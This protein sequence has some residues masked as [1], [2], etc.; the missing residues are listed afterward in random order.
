MTRA[1][2]A[3]D[4]MEE[5]A[6]SRA[7]AAPWHAAAVD[8]AFA[9]PGRACIVLDA[10][11]RIRRT[12]GDVARYLST[13]GAGPSDLE[14]A[15]AEPV[16]SLLRRT[17]GQAVRTAAPAAACGPWPAASGVPEEA[18]LVSVRVAPADPGSPPGQA[19]AFVAVIESDAAP[20]EAGMR[21]LAHELAESLG[22]CRRLREQLAASR[23]GVGGGP[24]ASNGEAFEPVL[25]A[26]GVGL[27]VF[28]RAGRVRWRTSAGLPFPVRDDHGV[29]MPPDVEP[30]EPAI[31]AAAE[32]GTESERLVRLP[33]GRAFR[34]SVHPARGLDGEDGS[35]VLTCVDVTDL[36]RA[37]T[38]LRRLNRQL[39]ARNAEAE[40]FAHTVSHDLKSPL[41]TIG[42]MMGLLRE[43]LGPGLDAESAGFVDQAEATVGSMRQTID[44]LLELS[45]VGRTPNRI[46]RV[47]LE[48]LVGEVLRTHAVALGAA[49]VRVRVDGPLPEIDADRRRLTQVVDNLVANAIAYGCGPELEVR[50]IEIDADL[51]GD[52]VILSVR[53]HGPGVPE[54]FAEQVF[55]LFQRL[56]Q[57]RPGTGVGLALVRRIVDAHGGRVWVE[58]AEGGGARF[59][60]SLP[61]T[62]AIAATAVAGA[63]S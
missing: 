2:D 9:P 17:L 23:G 1:P 30:I 16:R 63:E 57:D 34:L 18:G 58:P 35:V 8:L 54:A 40:A 29:T 11:G 49:G 53:D 28:D 20:A 33:D 26:A 47:A 60:V 24:P 43:T 27:V 14:A 10:S 19:A 51:R 7:A 48:P 37:E 45:R 12:L 31:E 4:A 56:R 13:P 42:C 32:H 38:Q 25:H 6:F 44:D 15:F 55:G 3:H 36:T 41:V 5:A 39:E 59:R 61:R 52:E 50:R 22:E 62:A 46:T 21:V